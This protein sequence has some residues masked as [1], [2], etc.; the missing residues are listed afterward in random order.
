M[1]FIPKLTIRILN[2]AM[3]ARRPPYSDVIALDLKL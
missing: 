3:K 2:M 1:L